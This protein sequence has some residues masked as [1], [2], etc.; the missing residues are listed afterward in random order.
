MSLRW[1]QSVSYC[2]RG[3]RTKFEQILSLVVHIATPMM[4]S[5]KLEAAELGKPNRKRAKMP[6][7]IEGSFS[8]GALLVGKWRTASQRSALL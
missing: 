2:A 1:R 6:A 5:Q 7:K 8:F 4:S 3:L